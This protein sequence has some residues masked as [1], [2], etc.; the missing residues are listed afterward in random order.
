VG[1]GDGREGS[2]AFCAAYED[3]VGKLQF[4]RRSIR[5][6]TELAKKPPQLLE[7]VVVHEMAHLIVRG[8]NDRFKSIMDQQLPHWRL[9]RQELNSAPVGHESWRY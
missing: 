6:N 4:R 3:Q 2:T 8:H 7:Y 1:T 5:L 9:H